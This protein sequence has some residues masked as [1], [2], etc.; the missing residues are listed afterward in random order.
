[1]KMT[2]QDKEMLRDQF[3]RVWSD[4]PH[5]VDYCVKRTSG[6]IVLDGFIVTYD[7]PHI[8]TRFCFGE[9]GYDYAEVTNECHQASES[10][11]YFMRENLRHIDREIE[12]VEEGEPWLVP[13]WHNAKD[14]DLHLASVEFPMWGRNPGG[15]QACPMSDEER[16][17]YADFLRE[18]RAKFEKRLRTYLKRYGLTKCH[19]WTYWADR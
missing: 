15:E 7:K 10:T 8:E 3:A 13:S 4:S 9:H 11:E 1:M 18:E 6:Y 14:E 19:Y 16:A 12:A 17:A 5:M 2:T